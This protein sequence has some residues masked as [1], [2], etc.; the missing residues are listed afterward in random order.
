MKPK[1]GDKVYIIHYYDL[2]I[3]DESCELCISEISK[4]NTRSIKVNGH[5]MDCSNTELIPILGDVEKL[6]FVLKSDKMHCLDGLVSTRYITTDEN[7]AMQKYKEIL[8]EIES[9]R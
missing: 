4:I 7:K 8:N 9:R 5:Y 2:F 6:N 1:I 3:E